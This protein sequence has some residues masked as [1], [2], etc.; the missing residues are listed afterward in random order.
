MIRITHPDL[1]PITPSVKREFRSAAALI[2]LVCA[3]FSFG[4]KASAQQSPSASI[5]G[6]W[7][8]LETSR[9]G[10]GAVYEFRSDG[11]VDFSYAAVV[12]SPWRIENNQLVLPPATVDGDEQKSTLQWLSDSKLRL[13]TDAS[14][15]ELTRVGDRPHA[16]NPLV[17]EWMEHR[18]CSRPYVGSSLV[19]WLRTVGHCCSCPSRCSKV[20]TTSPARRFI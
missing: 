9:G 17:G 15:I 4:L 6:R 10:L 16:D 20:P 3:N 8:S 7:R 18:A 19:V 1:G 11:T 14:V 5:V 13:K 12:E 2:L